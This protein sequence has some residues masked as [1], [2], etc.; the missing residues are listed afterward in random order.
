M[1]NTINR[2]TASYW[3]QKLELTAHVEG[4][5]FREVYRS[6]LNLPK[7]VLPLFFSGIA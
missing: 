5:A 7:T 2:P 3:I 6:E 1:I 4:G